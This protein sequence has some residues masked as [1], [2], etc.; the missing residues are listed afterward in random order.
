MAVL[1]FMQDAADA[2]DPAASLKLLDA[3]AASAAAA[4]VA[5]CGV[6][7]HDGLL[8]EG[9][10]LREARLRALAAAHDTSMV[11][12]A[13]AVQAMMQAFAATGLTDAGNSADVTWYAC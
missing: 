5:R 1:F 3:A 7:L 6:A 4:E 9:Q 13:A 2:A 11:R 12:A 8:A 10:Q